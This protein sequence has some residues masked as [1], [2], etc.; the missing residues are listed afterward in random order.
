MSTF[1]TDPADHNLCPSCQTANRDFESFCRNCGFPVGATATLDPIKS[2]QTEG[3]VFRKALEGRPKPV[4]L[5]GIWIM[6]LPVA[7]VSA[8]SAVYFIL[9]HRQLS[10]VIFFW[11]MVGLTFTSVVI[12]FRVTRN[13]IGAKRAEDKDR[14]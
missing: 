5:A 8:C 2:I 7:I 9:Y 10:D 4:V 3:L 11:A 13:F 6:F 14:Q 1:E 12:L